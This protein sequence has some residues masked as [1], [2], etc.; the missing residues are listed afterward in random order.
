MSSGQQDLAGRVAELGDA[1]KTSLASTT[2]SRRSS[3]LIQQ[4]PR[5]EGARGGGARSVAARTNT[6]ADSRTPRR[7]HGGAFRASLGGR[8]G[9]RATCRGMDGRR[10]YRTPV[11]GMEGPHNLVVECEDVM[12]I[13]CESQGAATSGLPRG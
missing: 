11:V 2:G 4:L 1:S 13:G 8:R 12:K 3:D 6:D 10:G 9:Y 7:G 5:D